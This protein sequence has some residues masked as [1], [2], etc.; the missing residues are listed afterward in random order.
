MFGEVWSPRFGCCNGRR[1]AQ[2]GAW[3]AAHV[4]HTF[5]CFTR[6]LLQLLGTC[7]NCSCKHQR[8]SVLLVWEDALDVC[9]G[10]MKR[11]G[12]RPPSQGL[13]SEE[14]GVFDLAVSAC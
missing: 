10:R 14:L 6:R 5:T 9:W 7:C 4:K 3:P 8:G 1:V 11:V 12:Q 2:W 13:C